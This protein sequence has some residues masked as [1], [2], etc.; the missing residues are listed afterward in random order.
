MQEMNLAIVDSMLEPMEADVAGEYAYTDHLPLEGF[1]R[2]SALS[3]LWIFG[4][5]EFLRTWRQWVEDVLARCSA[6]DAL[7]ADALRVRLQEEVEN[8]RRQSPEAPGGTPYCEGFER[9]ALKPDYRRHLKEALYRSD[10]PFR[11]IEA[12][13]VH[14]AKHEVPKRNVYGAGAGYGRIDIDSS[15]QFHV[16]LGKNEVTMISR[17]GIAKDLRRMAEGRP[18]FILNE[19]LQRAVQ[20]IPNSSYGIKR[21]R[22]TVDDGRTYEGAIA[23]GRHIVWVQGHP[24]PP[25]ETTRVVAV[26]ESE[27]EEND[28]PNVS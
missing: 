28:A 5:Y 7:D 23:W 8:L 11:R 2:V 3:Q 14:L 24:M 18:L 21:V 6:L 9:A 25:F 12:V 1:L 15:L 10:L 19:E 27:G 22:M 4:V 16:P 26:Q 20:R 17:R 13:R